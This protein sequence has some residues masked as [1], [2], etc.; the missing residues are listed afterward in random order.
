MYTEL[1]FYE[2]IEAAQNDGF[3]YFEFWGWQDKDIELIKELSEKNGIKVAGFSGD[4][5]L[6]LIDPNKK[7]EYMDFLKKSVAVA[8][9]LNA[10]ALTIHS[11]GL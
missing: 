11:N 7:T 2:R 6:S 4:A 1:Q 3:D 5:E 10:K 8:N 9:K